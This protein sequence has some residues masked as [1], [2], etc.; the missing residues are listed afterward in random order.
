MECHAITNARPSFHQS[1]L[2]PLL[3]PAPVPRRGTKRGYSVPRA[4]ENPTPVFR[5]I[6][7]FRHFGTPVT[8]SLSP[9]KVSTVRTLVFAS[10]SLLGVCDTP[11]VII[12]RGASHSS[13]TARQGAGANIHLLLFFCRPLPLVD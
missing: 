5:L 11:L 9:D 3:I 12:T 1:F 2:T 10:R 4:R 8:R 13:E 6:A 7:R